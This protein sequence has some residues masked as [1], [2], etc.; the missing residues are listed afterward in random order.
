MWNDHCLVGP[1]V[2]RPHVGVGP[3]MGTRCNFLSIQRVRAAQGFENRDFK[4]KFS[5]GA[6]AGIRDYKGQE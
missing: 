6:K 3:Y 2:D 1:F 5:S 4:E